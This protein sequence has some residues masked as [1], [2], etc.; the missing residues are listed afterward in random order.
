[1]H[2][3]RA[4]SLAL[5]LFL[6]AVLP[7]RG[8]G[9]DGAPRGGSFE[10]EGRVVTV[11]PETIAGHLAVIRRIAPEAKAPRQLELAWERAF[12]V[13]SARALGLGDD[14]EGFRAWM[15]RAHRDLWDSVI[16]DDAI[17]RGRLEAYARERGF[18]GLRPYEAYCRDE[19]R[20]SAF[21]DRMSPPAEITEEAIHAR[22]LALG[23]SF[24]VEAIAIAPETLPDE[25]TPRRE[26]P[27]DR[28][29]YEQWY[30]LV[31]DALK[32]TFDDA[33]HPALGAEALHVRYGDFSMETFRHWF[34]KARPGLEGRSLAELTADLE[35][36]PV[37]VARM[38]R[39]W[40]EGRRSSFAKLNAELPNGL[41]DQNSFLLVDA[42]L[43]RIWRTTKY[44]ERLWRAY[45][46][47]E[48]PIDLEA[49]AARHGFSYRRV[50]FAVRRDFDN[51]PVL[52][53]DHS[54]PLLDATAPGEFLDYNTGASTKET[55]IYFADG[56]VQQPGLYSAIFRL[57]EKESMRV[58]AADEVIDRAWPEFVRFGR[59]NAAQQ[60]ARAF[61][62]TWRAR[63]GEELAKTRD[64]S[65]AIDEAAARR[66]AFA[67][68]E[69]PAYAQRI[70]RLFVRPFDSRHPRARSSDRLGRR[71]QSFLEWR[72]AETA[73]RGPE[74]PYAV[75]D[76][77]DL[78]I[79]LDYRVAV[80]ARIDRISPTP[81][82]RWG[83]DPALRERAIRSLENDRDEA[84]VELTRSRFD[85]ERLRSRH[86]L[87]C[88]DLDATP[89]DK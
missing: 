66:A 82:A 4:R 42:H 62:G 54:K 28:A 18:G 34:E 80:L 22:F 88:P 47:S 69:I 60:A 73:R 45:R 78:A 51:D 19:Y 32:V 77:L 76:V 29:A 36:G 15:R 74:G 86:A 70:S 14:E 67:A 8:L 27:A 31:P 20:G 56:V 37:D 12:R 38:Q 89:S 87:R 59:W 30:A 11:A 3:V 23:T 85:L 1:M 40:A 49:E 26:V 75:G 13:E 9:Q 61:A 71:V 57:L 33:E 24:L 39:A 17:D 41:D 2:R 68:L 46:A 72:W 58:R 53:G 64:A 48:T 79:G 7:P 6:A 43:E 52:P 83:R 55:S 16:V 21:L 5:A 25:L 65:G 50:P 84:R 10:I 35:P 63:L 44:L 81:E